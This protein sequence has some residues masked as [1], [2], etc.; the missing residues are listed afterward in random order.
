MTTLPGLLVSFEGVDG[1]GKSTQAE[2]LC[3][4]LAGRG[5]PVGTAGAPGAV[6]RE[7]GGTEA[8]ERIRALLLHGPDGLAP[9]TEALLY[10]AA[11]AQLVAEVV[12]PAL[13]AGRVLVLDRF[14]D[15]S[16]AYQGHARGLGIDVVYA[17]NEPGLQGVLP[18][19]TFV[20]DVDPATGLARVGGSPDRIERE[21]LE[22]QRR[23]RHG[24]RE[25]A[26][27]YPGRVRLVDGE[28][29][30]GVVAAEIE[31]ECGRLLEAH[32]V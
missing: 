3:G 19:V 20:L 8:G 26:A 12:Q 5:L 30:P 17:L 13:A 15:S 2:L 32:R 10:A 25:L 14:L 31:A 22:F 23:V 29:P 9:W 11:R 24:F 27:R 4:A 7:P 16:L 18:D 6:I 28:R 1:C 21:G